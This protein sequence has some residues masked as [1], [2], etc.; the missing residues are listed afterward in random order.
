MSLEGGC[1]CG[2]VRYSVE[3]KPE[4]AALCHCGDCRASSGA[5]VMA[6][7][8]FQSADFSIL[9]G[10]PRVYESSASAV[11]YF[12]ADCGTGLWY[13]NEDVLPGLVDIQIATLDD[14]EALPPGA[15]IQAAEELTWMKSSKDLPHFDRYPGD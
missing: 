4:H 15:H 3:G 6:W 13:I 9:A 5:P 14:P 12:C 10:E 8:A 1:Q 2:Q 11:R 7:A